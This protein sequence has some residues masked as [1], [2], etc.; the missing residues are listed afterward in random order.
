MP[1]PRWLCSSCIAVNQAPAVEVVV[2]IDK[3]DKV[4]HGFAKQQD[5]RSRRGSPHLS[6]NMVLQPATLK[7]LAPSDG[8]EENFTLQ[9]L[10]ESVASMAD[11]VIHETSSN[12]PDVR[13]TFR[14]SAGIQVAGHKVPPTEA[15]AAALRLRLQLAVWDGDV[16]T[17]RMLLQE[18]PTLVSASQHTSG[19]SATADPE[20]EGTDASAGDQ[21]VL[22][23]AIRLRRLEIVNCLLEAGANILASDTDGW[24]LEAHLPRAFPDADALLAQSAELVGRQTWANWKES[25]LTIA[26]RLSDVPDCDLTLS[27][28]FS[29]WVPAVGRL[30]P[31]DKVR[32]RKMGARLRLDY[33]LKKF[34]GLSWEH[35]HCS[36]LACPDKDGAIYFLDN[37][38]EK[39]DSLERKLLRTQ[40][41]VQDRARRQRLRSLKRGHLR[42]DSVVMEDTG[43]VADC[44]DFR[45][46]KVYEMK[47]LEYTTEVLPRLA[48]TREK[49]SGS[50]WKAL[51]HMLKH[52]NGEPGP[53]A[54]D[55]TA[56]VLKFD[57]L[58]PDCEK[59]GHCPTAE[60]LPPPGISHIRKINAN[61]LMSKDFPLSCKHFL[62]IADALSVPDERYKTIKEFFEFL[63]L[64]TDQ[65]AT[66]GF[67]VQFTLPVITALS[68]TLSFTEAHLCE[69]D[70]SLFDV[71]TGFRQGKSEAGPPAASTKGVSCEVAR[72]PRMT[73]RIASS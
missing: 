10:S 9:Q 21:E 34:S 36:V 5:P 69:Q 30:L 40:S 47:G 24:R 62:A 65:Q 11:L 61:V 19:A 38:L 37:E 14:L 44:G 8:W 29:T 55:A 54:S 13:E 15:A 57:S 6:R 71:P 49:E 56:E 53:G 3:A 26:E 48:G 41:T 32:L 63:E 50:R 2:D 46:C 66:E 7:L 25:A 4:V 59:A 27:W 1:C 51:V 33:T 18:W 64:C 72:T 22:F 35:G 67:P 43:E 45:N 39:I 17:V 68:A 73:S 42:S 12:G 16:E 20:G 60:A 58:F 70:A 23:L 31:Q 28:A 52:L